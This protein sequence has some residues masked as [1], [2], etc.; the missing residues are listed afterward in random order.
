MS[1]LHCTPPA[2]GRFQAQVDCPQK[3]D[4]RRDLL[5]LPS[6]YCILMRAAPSKEPAPEATWP[7]STSPT[8][9]HSA[10]SHRIAGLISR[11]ML[12]H[13]PPLAVA[14]TCRCRAAVLLL[15]NRE[16][17]LQV[18]PRPAPDP[19]LPLPSR[20]ASSGT[21]QRSC[22]PNSLFVPLWTLRTGLT[23]IVFRQAMPTGASAFGVYVAGMSTSDAAW[24]CLFLINASA[25]MRTRRTL[26][27]E[28]WRTPLIA[29]CS[30]SRLDWCSLVED[31]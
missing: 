4:P 11:W 21:S 18:L 27:I 6:G 14:A 3:R 24:T 2:D 23:G 13:I 20:T 15:R 9:R 25:R 26:V 7:T 29:G 19:Q 5:P 10:T 31:R 12:S 28:V 1:A 17:L 16:L 8:P 30:T 22:S